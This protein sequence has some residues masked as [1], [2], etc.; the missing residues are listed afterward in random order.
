[1]CLW[2]NITILCSVCVVFELSDQGTAWV[3]HWPFS[4]SEVTRVMRRVALAQ[5][6]PS[7]ELNRFY[8]N[9]ALFS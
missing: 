6:W 8:L 9:R 7:E 5:Y 1:M 3:K 4:L 2:L